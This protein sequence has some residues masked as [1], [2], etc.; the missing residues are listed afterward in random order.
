[1]HRFK[2]KLRNKELKTSEC[3]VV[4]ERSCQGAQY[5][6]LRLAAACSK[7]ARTGVK[8]GKTR[9]LPLVLLRVKENIR[10]TDHSSSERWYEIV[11]VHFA[12]MTGDRQLANERYY[13]ACKYCLNIFTKIKL[14][15]VNRQLSWCF[16]SLFYFLSLISAFVMSLIEAFARLRMRSVG[17]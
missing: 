10:A 9:L 3:W 14:L 1:M 4:F 15:I 2:W 11:E 13:T 5:S 12:E 16:L 7:I 6:G 17:I 8:V